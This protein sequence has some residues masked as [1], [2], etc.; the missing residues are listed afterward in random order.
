M[1][2]PLSS[3]MSAKKFSENIHVIDNFTSEDGS[4]LGYIIDGGFLGNTFLCPP[5]SGASMKLLTSLDSLFRREYKENSF[6]QIAL[7]ASDDIIEQLNAFHSIRG[8]R[9][10]DKGELDMDEQGTYTA[11]YLQRL[12]QTT[13]PGPNMDGVPLRHFEV[14]VTIKNPIKKQLPTKKEVAEFVEQSN[15]LKET[16]TG[17]MG[18]AVSA[19]PEYFTHRMQ[20]LHT[21]SQNAVW[22]KGVYSKKGQGCYRPTQPIKQQYLENGTTLDVTP[23]SLIIKN[24]DNAEKHIKSVSIQE[25]ADIVN[26]GD[27]HETVVDWLHG[28]SAL[29]GNF[30]INLNVEFAKSKIQKAYSAR[31]T[32]AKQLGEGPWAKWVSSLKYGL[33]DFE[34]YEHYINRE[35]AQHC[36]AHLNFQIMASTADKADKYTRNLISRI[37]ARGWKALE[38]KNIMLLTWLSALPM[39]PTTHV[40]DFI[41]RYDVLP[42]NLIKFFVPMMASW[43]G[44]TTSNPVVTLVGRDGQL[45][46]FD[47]FTSETNYNLFITATSGSGKS[48]FANFLIEGLLSTGTTKFDS[49]CESRNEHESNYKGVYDGGR[50][51]AIDSGRSYVKLSELV[52]GQFVEVIPNESFMYN[53][54]PF[55]TIEEKFVDEY[56]DND[57]VVGLERCP[58]GPQGEMLLNILKLMA[59]PMGECT[60]YQFSQM[61]VIMCQI[62]KDHGIKGS[63]DL[64]A[65]MCSEH[66]DKRINEISDQLSPW[67]RSRGGQHGWMFNQNKPP[68]QFERSFVVL[69]LDGLNGSDQVKAVAIMLCIQRIQQEMFSHDPEKSSIRKMFLLDEAW[70]L[71]KDDKGADVLTREVLKTLAKFLESGW[72]RFRKYN[73]LG[74]CISQSIRDATE[75]P[76]GIAMASNS[77]HMMYLR[78]NEE[79]LQAFKAEGRFSN[80]TDFTLLESVHPNP[81]YYS[82]VLI[83]SNGAQEIGRLYMARAKGLSYSSSPKEKDRINHLVES[84]MSL[85]EACCSMAQSEGREIVLSP[86]VDHDNDDDAAA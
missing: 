64:F 31:R 84:G 48:F 11:K 30:I 62:W 72:R 37:E 71:L 59:F 65:E 53:L 10:K 5:L 44:N 61:S 4:H 81:P 7:V 12:S 51:F 75:S 15:Q 35:K 36:R 83:K 32:V 55:K 28:K 57:N 63:I 56:D 74:C 20:M 6:L 70:E 21:P 45:M 78:Q 29:Q 27:I 41:E 1:K 13:L 16:L 66:P 18:Y 80:P 86:P 73:S 40:A 46:M 49:H 82:E 3:L 22:R 76:A 68:I 60:S 67:C 50:V 23:S 9:M 42:S 69:E 38:D 52:G 33:Q 17:L 24:A 54:C 43:R 77:A 79:E 39:G 34:Y 58:I 2:T 26:F 47:P 14:W 25:Y 8:Q 85:W 19:E